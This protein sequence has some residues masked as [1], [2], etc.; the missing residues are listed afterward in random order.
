MPPGHVKDQASLSHTPPAW[1]APVKTMAMASLCM[2]VLLSAW[3]LAALVQAAL[4]RRPDRLSRLLAG[5][6]VLL[7]PDPPP[8]GPGPTELSVLRL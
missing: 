2:A 1:H 5:G 4:A 7:G 6:P 8:R 3:L